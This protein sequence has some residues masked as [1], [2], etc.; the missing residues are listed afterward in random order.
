MKIWSIRDAKA[1]FSDVVKQAATK[2]PQQITVH[3]KPAAVLLSDAD[4]QK[5]VKARPRFLDF[6]SASPLVG[7]DLDLSRDQSPPRDVDL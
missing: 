4:Y 1:R 7:A 3:G 5:L 6:M 2:G